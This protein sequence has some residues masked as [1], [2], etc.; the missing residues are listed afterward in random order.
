MNDIYLLVFSTEGLPHDKCFDLTQCTKEIKDKLSQHFK[1]VWC[2][3]PRSLKTLPG[4]EAFCNEWPEQLDMNPNA[5]NVGYFDFKSF[6]IDYTL[7]KI[8]EGSILVYHDGNFIK[9]QQYWHTDWPRLHEICTGLLASNNSDI[10]MQFEQSDV[11]VKHHVKNYVLTTMFP[12][13][14]EQ[15]IVENCKL[16]NA[17]R[18]I[19]RNSNFSRTFIKDYIGL[20]LDKSLVS[21]S[22]IGNKHLEFKWSCG[23]QDVLN[24]LVY[25]YILDGKLCSN[26]PR[27]TFLYRVIRIENRPFTWNFPNEQKQDWHDRP[28]PTGI[29]EVNNFEIV[30]YIMRRNK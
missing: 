7:S 1:D 16:I 24:A 4:S 29:Q 22:P 26:F 2:Y 30:N 13:P 25:R 15:N 14:N 9:N 12:N 6:L 27:Y 20:C 28:H 11:L 18:I 23:D 8:P 5:N 10:F 17:A 21:K 19:L 3:T